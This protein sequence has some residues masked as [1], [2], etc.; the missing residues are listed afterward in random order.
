MERKNLFMSFDIW[1]NGSIEIN[2]SRINNYRLQRKK[3]KPNYNDD[4]EPN[5]LIKY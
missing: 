2:I 1:K 3:N 4:N 5:Y